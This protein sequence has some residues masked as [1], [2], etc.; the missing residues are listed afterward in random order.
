[1][2]KS[3]L[4]LLPAALAGAVV[5][6]ATVISCG[7]NPETRDEKYQKAQAAIESYKNS[8]NYRVKDQEIKNGVI[9]GGVFG[10]DN[11]A[12]LFSVAP[13]QAKE[14]LEGLYNNKQAYK[15]TEDTSLAVDLDQ[16]SDYLDADG[17]KVTDE[18]GFQ[19][20]N[21]LS[22]V[23]FPWYNKAGWTIYMLDNFLT[24]ETDLII[25]G[26][27]KGQKDKNGQI[28]QEDQLSLAI[29]DDITFYPSFVEWEDGSVKAHQPYPSDA[30]NF[31][32]TMQASKIPK[33]QFE[34]GE[35][36]VKGLQAYI[37]ISPEG[38]VASVWLAG[39][40]K[41]PNG[42]EVWSAPVNKKS[43]TYNSR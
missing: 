9:K 41:L 29:K 33:V 10:G 6:V 32:P 43:F 31:W 24:P 27:L 30:H 7:E 19:E 35:A 15:T 13:K 25:T 26:V 5:P 17:K 22:E 3:K 2:R 4:F 1:M 36:E 11:I 14:I 18:T 28:Y 20:F 40:S 12:P 39:S 23:K 37:A 42:N 21:S 8:E 16:K 38:G 34:K